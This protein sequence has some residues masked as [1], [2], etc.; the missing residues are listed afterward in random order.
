MIKKPIK[1]YKI[2]LCVVSWSNNYKTYLL[3]E[4]YV[5]DKSVYYHFD[6]IQKP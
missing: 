1:N 4:K 3:K 2:R 5:Y 6:M